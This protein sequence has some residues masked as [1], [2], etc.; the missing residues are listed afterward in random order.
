MTNTS[1]FDTS[2]V[3]FFENNTKN[4]SYYQSAKLSAEI[5]EKITQELQEGGK[6]KLRFIP[7]E[8]RKKVAVW[9]DVVTPDKVA[10][11]TEAFASKRPKFEKRDE[12]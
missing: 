6:L 12:V 5:I 2:L 3:G 10:E 1:K 4:G 7:K 9:L 11:A 8:S